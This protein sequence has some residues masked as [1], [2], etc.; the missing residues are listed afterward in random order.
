[1][2]SIHSSFA[3]TVP[4]CVRKTPD[5]GGN[6]FP[7]TSLIFTFNAAVLTPLFSLISGR[8]PRHLNPAMRPAGSSR[9]LGHGSHFR[10]ISGRCLV[11]RP[12]GKHNGADGWSAIARPVASQTGPDLCPTLTRISRCERS[13]SLAWSRGGCCGEGDE[14]LVG[15]NG[16]KFRTTALF[17]FS[18]C[19]SGRGSNHFSSNP[20]GLFLCQLEIRHADKT[21]AA[22]R[23]VFH[24][25][26]VSSNCRDK[27]RG[28]PPIGE[29]STRSGLRNE[30]GDPGEGIVPFHSD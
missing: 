8:A 12:H 27:A 11:S 9:A 1:M 17:L 25:C 23:F 3:D 21:S 14:F 16:R 30:P 24:F 22:F 19:L 5:Q 26:Q 15:G 10:R 28:G 2:C 6:F 13:S 4:F 18:I 7:A 20:S 29:V